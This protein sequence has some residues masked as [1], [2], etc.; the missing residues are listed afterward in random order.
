ML[1]LAVEA[2]RSRLGVGRRTLVVEEAAAAADMPAGVG[3][4]TA[5]ADMPAG[6]GQCTAAADV[7]AGLGQSTVVVA[8][9]YVAA[10]C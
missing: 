3:Q 8:G 2:T 1:H 7:P 10:C 4:S 5:A 6:V 9:Y